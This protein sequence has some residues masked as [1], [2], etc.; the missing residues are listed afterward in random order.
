MLPRKLTKL[1]ETTTYPLNCQPVCRITDL[2][3]KVCEL[4]DIPSASLCPVHG[5][6]IEIIMPFKFSEENYPFLVNYLHVRI[7]CAIIWSVYGSGG[8]VGKPHFSLY[9]S[10]KQPI[11]LGR[12]QHSPRSTWTRRSKQ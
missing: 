10:P 9:L 5:I 2:E 11:K 7:V 6:Q 12:L 3:P 8:K 4:N 1:T